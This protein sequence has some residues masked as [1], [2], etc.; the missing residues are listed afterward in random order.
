MVKYFPP[1]DTHIF[2]PFKHLPIFSKSSPPPPP[3][4]SG[5]R[6]REWEEVEVRVLLPHPITQRLSG[7]GWG[8]GGGGRRRGECLLGSNE[9]RLIYR[10][11]FV[12]RGGGV[13]SWTYVENLGRKVKNERI[14]TIIW[15]TSN[16]Q[17]HIS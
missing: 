7:G 10:S 2:N 16:S 13:L 1:F 17:V 6:V 14:R 5:P 8:G 3:V 12:V 9:R 11:D 15:L 4:Y